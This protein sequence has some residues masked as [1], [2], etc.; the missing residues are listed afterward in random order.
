MC[1]RGCFSASYG[2]QPGQSGEIVGG[3]CR[4]EAGSDA[5]DAAIH[6][7]GHAAHGFRPAKCLFDLLPVL[8][9]QGISLMPGGAAINCECWM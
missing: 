7:L 1:A 8:L 6:G 9:G 3:H 5:F 2:Q 4:D